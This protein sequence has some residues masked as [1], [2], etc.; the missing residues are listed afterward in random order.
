MM[1]LNLKHLKTLLVTNDYPPIVSGI[2]TVFYHV[3]R[4]LPA[5]KNIILAPR[6]E[7]SSAFDKKDDLNITRYPFF[8]KKNVLYKL[9]NNLLMFMYILSFIPKVEGIHCG[10]ILSSGVCG[11]LFKKL[12]KTPYFLWVYGGETTPVYVN[13]VWSQLLIKKI[14]DNASIIITNSKFTSREFIEYGLSHEKVVEIIPGVDYE[15]FKPF[16]KPSD[17]V[18]EYKLQGKKVVLTVSRLTE[19]KGHDIV[20]KALPAVLE[21]YP[22]LS[23]II[24]GDGPCK[25]KLKRLCQ[26][27]NLNSVVTFV[28]FITDEGLVK[29]YNLCDIFV[30]PNREISDSTDSVEGFGITFIEANACNKPVIGGRSGGAIE[31]VDDGVTGFLVD[32]LNEKEL[33]QKIIYLLHNEKSARK[34]GKNGRERVEK[35]FSWKKRAQE[36]SRAFEKV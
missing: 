19:R 20:L 21:S 17:L 23:Y 25:T 31:A 10:Q 3:W 36:L 26:K 34:M 6:V 22:N 29:Y 28:G 35:E 15:I 32:P 9:I 14:L 13:S 30:M 1:R 24:V 4:Y 2:S 27:L 18:E 12:F 11:L 33:S 7:G 5:D 16:P 8:S